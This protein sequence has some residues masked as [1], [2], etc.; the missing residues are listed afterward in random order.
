MADQSTLVKMTID[1]KTVTVP[2]GTT[3]YDAAQFNGVYIP[4]ICHQQHMPPVAVCRICTVEV[5]GQW[6][7]APACITPV[8]EGMVVKT[9]ETSERAK[10]GVVILTELLLAD[11]QQPREAHL[12]YGEN[13][14]L[15]IARRYKIEKSRF[16]KTP[17]DRGYDDS[18]VVIA[19]DHNACILCDRC[20]RGCNE[21]A[22]NHVLGRR[23]KGYRAGIGFDLN[24]PM[25][26][27]SCI[28]CGE[29]MISCPTGA[30]TNRKTVDSEAF[31][32]EAVDLS[33]E[34][35]FSHELFKGVSKQFLGF[36]QHSIKRRK[37]KKGEIICKEGEFGSTAYVIEKGS[38]EVYLEA[39]IATA[40]ARSKG[41]GSGFMG[42]LKRVTGLTKRLK[43]DSSLGGRRFIHV[44]ATKA[45]DLDSE[46]P[47]AVLDEEDLIFGEMTCMNNYPRSATV[48]ARTDV[49]VL[50]VLRNVLYI[51]QRN[52]VTK[53][54]LDAVYKKRAIEDHLR[55]VPLFANLSHDEG[56][57]Q[58]FVA[59]MREKVELRRLNPG[60]VIFE[61][62]DPADDFYLVR[63]GFVKVAQDYRGE[64]HVVAYIGPG[65]YFG[66][67]GL[68]SNLP[69]ISRLAP[70]GIRTATCTSLDHLD[71]IKIRGDDFIEILERFPEVKEEVV[72]QAVEHLE[73]NEQAR[74]EQEN[75]EL[76]E[77][78]RQGLYEGQS[79][80]V[81]DLEKCT[82]CDEC[83]KAC[84]DAH[85]GITR[86]IRDGLRY[87]N[88]LVAS[89]CRSCL[90]P[91]CMVGCPVGSIRRSKG[92]QIIIEPWCIGCGRCAQ[93]CPYGNINMHPFETVEPDAMTGKKVAVTQW[94]A[95]VCD[96]CSDIDGR[97]SCVYACP[98][99]AAH[100]YDGDEFRS[101]IASK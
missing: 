99:D 91:Y 18:S 51:L 8:R 28:A 77:F 67:I 84:S 100:R 21:I 53:A 20:I 2:E 75:T 85:N 14:L 68:L 38:V 66:E 42:F 31:D 56:R 71:L 70:A 87:D 4:I 78:V 93:N 30:L 76:D 11:H 88:W 81:L 39:S 13:E 10:T 59:E 35:L 62:G 95:T 79:L 17:R 16:P 6:K 25:G 43:G 5:E 50:E 90:D 69:E 80:L 86:L 60:E 55:S 73:A 52:K 32:D 24:N 26:E 94:K 89:A 98:H 9:P 72:R 12:E 1:G 41:K 27:S 47:I 58:E 15:T 63:V 82:R 61:Q 23:G 29:C 96:L 97:P 34:E 45:I 36:N 49:T 19:V 33:P 74:Q 22:K 7:L 92:K 37:Y 44:D 40:E 101:M 65:G 64:T 48:R 57:F 46:D 54:K 3:I 83:T